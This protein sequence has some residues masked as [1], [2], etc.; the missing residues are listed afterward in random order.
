MSTPM[1][2]VIGAGNM[3]SSLIGGL[4][5]SGHPSNKLIACDLNE[6]KLAEWQKNGIN[7]SKDYLEAAKLADIIVLA[8]KPR[9]IA[10]TACALA[11]VIQDKKPL[12]L[13][14]AAG[15]REASLEHC[16]GKGIAIVRAMPNTPA[17]IGCGAAAMHANN[18]VSEEQHNQAESI[19][20]SVGIAIWLPEEAQMDAVTALSGSGPAY[21]FLMMEAMQQAAE[22]LGLPS[23]TARLLTLQTAL[24]AARMAIESGESLAKLRKDVTSPGGTT[25]KALAIFEENNIRD[26]YHQ[27]L[28]GAKQRSEELAEIM[29]KI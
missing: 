16:L 10:A 19:M 4:I 14:I 11:R 9:D 24:G 13:S 5:N 17:L 26:I 6:D 3:G 2:T 28:S 15:I 23:E 7:T 21:F 18:H 12:V 29:G 25:E 27:A 20:R 8:I 1:I 22:D